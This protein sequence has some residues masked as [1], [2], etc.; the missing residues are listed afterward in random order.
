MRELIKSPKLKSNLKEKI[1]KIQT[2]EI[3]V[4]M[5]QS[6]IVGNFRKLILVLIPKHELRGNFFLF[7][8]TKIIPT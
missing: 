6:K 8:S 1:G 4:L 5:A 2:A 3:I 7:Y